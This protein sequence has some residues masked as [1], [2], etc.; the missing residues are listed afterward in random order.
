MAEVLPEGHEQIVEGDPILRGEFSTQRFFAL[1][2]GFG[3]DV[4]PAVTDPVHVDIHADARFTVADRD[5]EVRR[6]PSYP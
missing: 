2:R 4:A 5:D 3:L 1:V 6:L